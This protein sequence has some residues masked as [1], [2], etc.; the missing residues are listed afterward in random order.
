M[1][2]TQ[3]YMRGITPERIAA[4]PW[5]PACALVPVMASLACNNTQVNL[6]TLPCG[7]AGTL[8][9]DCKAPADS[10]TSSAVPCHGGCCLDWVFGPSS[11]VPGCPCI[12]RFALH[13]YM[14]CTCFF[15]RCLYGV[16]TCATLQ[17][18]CGLAGSLPSTPLPSCGL[19]GSLP[20]TPLPSSNCQA[21][22]V[23]VC[24][25]KP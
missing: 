19:A 15:A 11:A 18:C 12:V 5:L 2:V 1:R 6:A 13:L 7:C 8:C 23:T 17:A 4:G 14:M 25:T 24:C 20:S 10:L 21:L 22:P 16:G 3:L 9:C